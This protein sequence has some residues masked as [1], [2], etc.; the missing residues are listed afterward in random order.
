M[1]VGDRRS[2]HHDEFAVGVGDAIRAFISQRGAEPVDALGIPNRIHYL[3]IACFAFF[4]ALVPLL[5]ALLPN[6]AELRQP[7]VV[8]VCVGGVA[9]APVHLYLGRRWRWKFRKWLFQAVLLYSIVGPFIA[10]QSL[11][12]MRPAILTLY[13]L[14]PIGAAFYFPL[15]RALPLIALGVVAIIYM[16]TQIDEP[17]AM[18]RGILVA[19]ITVGC[20]LMLSVMKRHLVQTVQSNHEISERDALTGVYNLHK[21]D[22]RLA[23]EIARSRRD[24][25]GFA[26]IEFDLDR[27]KPVND[28]YNHTVGDDVLMATA[29]AIQSVLSPADLLVRRGGD[30][31]AVIAPCAPERDLAA[32]IE[33]ACDRIAIAR[34]AL[35]PDMLPTASV[36]WVLHDEPETAEAI[37]R[38]AD[39]ALRGAKRAAHEREASANVRR[40]N[41]VPTALSLVAPEGQV[42]DL[43]QLRADPATTGDDP[44][45][46][47]MRIA[48]LTA[49]IATLLLSA[50]LAVMGFGGMTSFDFSPAVIALLAVWVLVIFPFSI[51]AST[52]ED[53][54]ARMV[55]LLNLSTLVLIT[56]SCIS[57]GDSAPV[58]VEMYLLAN[59]IFWALLPVISAMAYS[60]VG[61][62]LYGYFLFASGYEFAELRLTT[63]V[64]NLG[65]VGVILAINRQRTIEVANE[66]A[67]LARTDALTGLPNMRRLRER[68]AYEIRRCDT[69]GDSVALLLFDLNEFRSVNAGYGHP[70]GDAV[71]IAVANALEQ[72]ARH[73]DM[74]ARRGGNE[75]VVLL[76]DAGEHNAVAASR[77]VAKAIRRTRLQITAD[78]NPNAS[79]SW[80]VWRRGES[81]DALIHRADSSLTRVKQNARRE[82]RVTSELA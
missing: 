27:F 11:H 14:G 77:R 28:V 80:V 21:F 8:A 36:G 13:M 20:S 9:I 24:S 73:A 52:R 81:A 47:A 7:A 68:L 63:T 75:F 23:E 79:V 43:R 55:H 74:P 6:G 18:L 30:E 26:L 15:R 19:V 67:Q 35:C 1:N 78:I 40:S 37:L 64:V 76:T 61:F 66:K 41:A 65:F 10:Q 69:T 71:L 53:Q 48:W 22:E 42:I 45:S 57:I 51:W 32:M 46:G 58:A 25:G 59:V 62:G 54:P 31:F 4:V 70:T 72:T 33:F 17:D 82:R 38:R 16:S 49:G 56:L 3:A 60:A 5:F 44:I 39:D 50:A 29:E 2:A 12:E 34:H